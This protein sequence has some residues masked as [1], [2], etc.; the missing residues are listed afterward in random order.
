MKKDRRLGLEIKKIS[1]S[2]LNNITGL[3]D[4][5]VTSTHFKCVDVDTTKLKTIPGVDCKTGDTKTN[6]SLVGCV[7][8][9]S[10][11]C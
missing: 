2:K 10:K 9:D 11:K 3:G 1:I 7:V 4:N 5:A 6:R 8:V